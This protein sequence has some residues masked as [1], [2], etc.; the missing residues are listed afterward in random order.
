MARTFTTDQMNLLQSGNV[1][2]RLLSDWYLDDG[3]HHFCD[4]VEDLSDGSTTWIGASVLGVLG[5]IKSSGQ[6]AA[7]SV[8]LIVDGTRLGIS[9]FTDPGQLFRDILTMKLHQRRV[10]FSF[11]LMYADSNTITLQIPIYA[12]KINNAK[13]TYPK[14]NFDPQGIAVPSPGSLTITFDSLAARYGRVTGRTRSHADQQEIDPT[15]KFFEFVVYSDQDRTLFWGKSN[16]NDTNQKGS[17]E[18]RNRFSSNS[19]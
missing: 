19:F 8:S 1:K 3:T 6:F 17:L 5:D 15:D 11:G 12:A 10:D 16:P 18:Y 13:V 14:A 2:L 4:D 9:G 7:E